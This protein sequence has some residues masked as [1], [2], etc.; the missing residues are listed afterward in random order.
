MPPPSASRTPPQLR[1][2]GTS[3]L[4]LPG[5]LVV[6]DQAVFG[7]RRHVV[8]LELVDEGGAPAPRE[9]LQQFWRILRRDLIDQVEVVFIVAAER[10]AG[11]GV[12][13]T[14]AQGG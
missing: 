12:D 10:C 5:Q 13:R 9:R 6:Q 14:V 2:G 1:W 11:G 8:G 3:T 7:D 4:P